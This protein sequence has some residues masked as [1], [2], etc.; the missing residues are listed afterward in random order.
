MHESCVSR[1]F[2][3]PIVEVTL[4][5]KYGYLVD[6]CKNLLNIDNMVMKGYCSFIVARTS[7]TSIHLYHYPEGSHILYSPP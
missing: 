2:R 4:M 3:R 1:I 5:K 7:E 6:C